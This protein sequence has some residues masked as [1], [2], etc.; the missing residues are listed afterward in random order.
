MDRASSVW[1]PKP[2]AAA[3]GGFLAQVV[4]VG[5]MAVLALGLP[6]TQPWLVPAGSGALGLIAPAQAQPVPLAKAQSDALAAYEKALTDFKTILA[7]RRA[8]VDAKTKLPNLPGQALYRARIK[9]MSTYKE[10][11]DALPGRIG[12]PNKFG[13]PPAYFDADIEP[14]I[15]E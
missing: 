5:Q 14:L 9:V 11:T 13:V 15:E 4:R 10:L 3:V 1:I 6:F 8:Q 2:T 7:Q 12:R